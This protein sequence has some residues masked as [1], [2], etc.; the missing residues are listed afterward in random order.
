MSTVPPISIRCDVCNAQP[1]EP[2]TTPTH[3]GWRYVK[4]FHQ[5]RE[6]V[7]KYNHTSCQ[8]CG[9]LLWDV[10]RD[11]GGR[12]V[13]RSREHDLCPSPESGLGRDHKPR[14][15]GWTAAGEL[16]TIEDGGAGCSS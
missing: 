6:D 13:W 7:V 2:C 5:R 14:D 12:V 8:H 16:F 9:D 11:S 4:W 1:G 3:G 10:G 15:H